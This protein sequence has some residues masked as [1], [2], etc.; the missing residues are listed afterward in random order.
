MSS[1]LNRSSHLLYVIMYCHNSII[2][3]LLLFL[4][5]LHYSHS[6]KCVRCQGIEC[7]NLNLRPEQCPQDVKGCLSILTENWVETNRFDI[8]RDCYTKEYEE[9]CTPLHL[10][11]Q[12]CEYCDHANGCNAEKKEP[13]ICRHCDYVGGTEGFKCESA[14][15]CQP[16]FR[17]VAPQCHVSW[18]GHS[19]GTHYGC[20]HQLN[21]RARLKQLA[22]DQPNLHTKRCDSNSC[23]SGI[24]TLFENHTDLLELRRF[25][26]T[27][28]SGRKSLVHC[29]NFMYKEPI[30]PF[31]MFAWS[32]TLS[33]LRNGDCYSEM[34]HKTAIQ[35]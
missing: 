27:G 28:K 30:I 34:Y 33:T 13:L 20:W 17:T 21:R 5:L 22:T 31:C 25:C 19:D 24:D 8:N 11:N 10:A 9:L 1:I 14:L 2:I 23:N 3:L 26:Y 35:R 16:M 7:T 29:R 6:I 15:V 32:A 18:A 4:S 12:T